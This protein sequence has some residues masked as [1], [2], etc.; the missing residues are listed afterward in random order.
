M[1]FGFETFATAHAILLLILK[2]GLENEIYKTQE[3]HFSLD[4]SSTVQHT[5]HAHSFYYN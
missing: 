5:G 3:L 2:T 4:I 1:C